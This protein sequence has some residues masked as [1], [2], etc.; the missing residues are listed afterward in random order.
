MLV[1]QYNNN[2]VELFPDT[3]DAIIVDL[4]NDDIDYN[5]TIPVERVAEIARALLLAQYREG[6]KTQIEACKIPDYVATQY[7]ERYR[8]ENHP[9]S[10]PLLSKYFRMSYLADA[11]R[12][13]IQEGRRMTVIDTYKRAICMA[14]KTTKAHMPK[15]NVARKRK[16]A[17]PSRP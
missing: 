6:E 7:Y 14:K 5:M 11:I 12:V 1:R 9:A 3:A 8:A 4:D 2:V 15:Q 17:H 10:D 13:A 16:R